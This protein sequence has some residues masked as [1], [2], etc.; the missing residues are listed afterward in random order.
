MIRLSGTPFFFDLCLQ[1]KSKLNIS[2][3]YLAPL[4]VMESYS[5]VIEVYR[6]VLVHHTVGVMG[7]RPDL[8]GYRTALVGYRDHNDSYTV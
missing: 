3:E 2:F 5:T 1:T 4:T 7:F 6:A 8:V